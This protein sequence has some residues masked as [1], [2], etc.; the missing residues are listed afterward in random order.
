MKLVA[1]IDTNQQKRIFEVLREES[2]T[3]MFEGF[4]NSD[5]D[6]V[7]SLFKVLSFKK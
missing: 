5:L 4:S 3:N 7:Q 2:S 6:L 1:D